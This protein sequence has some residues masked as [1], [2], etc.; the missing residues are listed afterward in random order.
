MQFDKASYN[1]DESAGTVTVVVT[2]SST[3]GNVSVNYVTTAGTATAGADYTTTSGTL[4]FASGSATANI[5][6]PLVNNT[7]GELKET[8][9]LTLS[10]PVGATLGTRKVATVSIN[11]DDPGNA[12]IQ[13]ET[14]GYSVTEGTARVTLRVTRSNGNGTATVNFATANITALAGSDCAAR[15]GTLS[16]A[17]GVTSMVINVTITNNTVAEPVETF[18]VVLSAPTGGTLGATATAT[19]TITD[20]E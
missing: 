15:S 16:F 6:V 4:S 19:V 2:R 5:V 1:V 9:K 20:N 3:V 13:F 18:R 7:V 12:V 10:S 8:F 17:P 11:D 14:P